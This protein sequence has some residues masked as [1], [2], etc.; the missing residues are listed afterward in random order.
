MLSI[1]LLSDNLGFEEEESMI[2][3]ELFI[4]SLELSLAN[5]E[6]ALE[7]NDF[8][9]IAREAHAIKG[10]SANLLLADIVHIA[11]QLEGAAKSKNRDDIL[12]LTKK[13]E[14]MVEKLN[15]VEYDYA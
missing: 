7:L 6:D 10:S 11:K 3:L 15:K 9:K 4:E 13:I 1:K 2:L 14:N 5:I 8:E 12:N